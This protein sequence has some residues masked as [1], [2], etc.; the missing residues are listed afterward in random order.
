MLKNSKN[1]QIKYLYFI[2]FITILPIL[3]YN[4]IL[5]SD[6]NIVIYNNIIQNNAFDQ[7]SDYSRKII[8]GIE[9]KNISSE[10]FILAYV[11]DAFLIVSLIIY[12]YL[13][14]NKHKNM[15]NIK[16]KYIIYNLLAIFIIIIG[17]VILAF[18]EY[19]FSMFNIWSHC[20]KSKDNINNILNFVFQKYNLN[21]SA[22]DY[23]S[24]RLNNILDN[25][26]K[27]NNFNWLEFKYV[28]IFNLSIILLIS[29]SHIKSMFILFH[30]E[31]IDFQTSINNKIYRRNNFN[32][33]LLNRIN[34]FFLKNDHK[35]LIFLFIVSSLPIIIPIAI[36]YIDIN[37]KNSID[38]KII[39]NSYIQKY[40]FPN[41]I[42]I[43]KFGYFKNNFYNLFNISELPSL[44][45]FIEI[46]FLLFF[47]FLFNKKV[48]RD[49]L[50]FKI[51]IIFY[52]FIELLS[53]ITFC[54]SIIEFNSLVNYWN[55]NSKLLIKILFNTYHIKSWFVSG[56]YL[57]T[58]MIILIS[59]YLFK[60]FINYYKFNE[61]LQ[62]KTNN[63]INKK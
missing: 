42:D 20:L 26:N 29:F 63:N 51:I 47:I 24:N 4:I 7:I 22:K 49:N 16:Q 37:Y 59:Y 39:Y 1:P 30:F 5:F 36:F 31:T 57:I 48:E 15:E 45:L 28:W 41:N 25:I 27:K 10:V 58:F 12:M 3:V 46:S 44:S 6:P 61:F 17:M 54:Y 23:I 14:F 60:L 33:S 19:F 38:Y 2:I 32:S 21:S 11:G 9:W 50:Y 40:L 13:L 34:Y 43:I 18:S 55:S 62:D 35:N 56:K 53:V 8:F 52:I